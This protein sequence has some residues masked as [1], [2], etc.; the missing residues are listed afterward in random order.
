MQRLKKHKKNQSMGRIRRQD[1]PNMK[2][3]CQTLNG[4]NRFEFGTRSRKNIATVHVQQTQKT[5]TIIQLI[6][7][8]KLLQRINQ[9]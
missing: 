6:S 2:Q 8:C 5:H 4:D 3:E 9:M 7:N 1:G